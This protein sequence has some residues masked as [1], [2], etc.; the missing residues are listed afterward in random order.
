VAVDHV[1][2]TVVLDASPEDVWR[3]VSDEAELAEWF[4]A[5]VALDPTPGGRGRFD[6]PGGATRHAVVEEVD[7]GRRLVWRWWGDDG[8]APSRVAL[9][10][11]RVDGGTRLTVVEAPVV[12]RAAAGEGLRAARAAAWDRRLLALE[13]RSLV[14]AGV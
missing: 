1:E 12:P 4:G 14:P 8:A 13:L 5:D 3:A 2:R 11:E 10:V 6:E 7:E 9:T